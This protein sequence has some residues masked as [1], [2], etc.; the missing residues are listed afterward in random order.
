[1]IKYRIKKSPAKGVEVVSQAVAEK[2]IAE[3][4]SKRANIPLGDV[5]LVL[6]EFKTEVANRLVNGEKI[7]LVNFGNFEVFFNSQY[8]LFAPRFNPLQV[9]R[10]KIKK[11]P[12]K[13]V[14]K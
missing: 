9:L 1:M 4:I 5:M 2:V 14:K 7:S 3:T 12:A 10:D 11:Q 8:E 13:I 6:D